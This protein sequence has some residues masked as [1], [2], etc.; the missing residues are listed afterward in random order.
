MIEK[1]NIR[2]NFIIICA[3]LLVSG[4]LIFTFLYLDSTPFKIKQ[5]ETNWG[6]DLP[7]KLELD[8]SANQT[9][10]DGSVT[11]HVLTSK[12]VPPEDLFLKTDTT[13]GKK[14]FENWLSSAMNGFGSTAGKSNIPIEFRPDL[15]K[16]YQYLV[17]HKRS[18][19]RY[20][21]FFLVFYPE[22]MKLII[23]SEIAQYP[24]HLNID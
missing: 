6:I 24:Y 18:G 9:H 22:T 3:V 1:Q 15:N 12:H 19:I 13:I 20:S 17:L 14:D 2:S 21:Y 4:L 11:Y 23:C 16:E 7:D 5:Y 10:I 8:F